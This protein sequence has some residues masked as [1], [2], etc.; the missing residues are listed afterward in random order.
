MESRRK[1]IWLLSL[2][3]FLSLAS[4]N[5]A[6]AGSSALTRFENGAFDI[7]MSMDYT[8]DATGKTNIE[9][10]LNITAKDIYRMTEGTHHIRRFYIYTPDRDTGATRQWDKA[11]IRF[12]STPN[13]VEGYAQLNG[14]LK[15]GKY[16]YIDEDLTPAWS[17][18]DTGNAIAH[19]MGHYIY[20]L[21]DEYKVNRGLANELIKGQ[22]HKNDTPKDTIMNHHNSFQRLSVSDDYPVGA[23]ETAQW[24]M[25]EESAW[26]VLTQPPSLDSVWSFFTSSYLGMET[27]RYHFTDLDNMIEPFSAAR[28]TQPTNNP[29]PEIIWMEG[30]EACIIID[31]SGSM[32]TD[33][34]IVQA[35]SGAKSY[36]DKLKVTGSN[37]D[38]AAVVSFSNSVSTVKPLTQ[39]TATIKNEF[40][41]A[42]DT[43]SAN[44]GTAIGSA[45]RSGLNILSASTR[46]GTFKYIILL[47]DGQNTSG[48]SPTGAILTDLKNA[49]IPVYCIGLGSG[50]D[51]STLNLIARA[52]NGKSY[53][54]SS[55]STLNSVYS[56][57]QSHVADDV[58]I[59]WE[60]ENLNLSRNTKLTT[61]RVD[62]SANSVVFS[63]AYPIDE[64]ATMN[65]TDPN[66]IIVMDGDPGVSCDTETGYI[67]CR[68]D[69]PV[70][71]DWQQQIEINS[72]DVGDEGEV[73]LEAKS[74]SEFRAQVEV[75]GGTYPEPIIIQASA[76]RDFP[77]TG[78]NATCKFT[79][80]D[81][82]SVKTTGSVDLFDDGAPPDREAD[83]GFYTGVLTDYQNGEYDFNVMFVNPDGNSASEVGTSFVA[84]FGDL[85]VPVP[86]AAAFSVGSNSSVT[87]SGVV[88]DDHTDLNSFPSEVIVDGN[89]VDGRIEIDNDID[90]FYFSAE[91]NKTY[92]I[93]TYGLYP[94]D[95]K[96]L[97]TVYASPDMTDVIASDSVGLNNESA[98]IV[99]ENTNLA[100]VY[101]T[102][103][104]S[105]PGTGN[106]KIAVRSSQAT[107]GAATVTTSG[108]PGGGGNTPA[109]SGG[110]GG[111]GG[112]GCF[113]GVINMLH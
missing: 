60:K 14:F 107:D 13:T 82:S 68:V 67:S 27:D 39:L 102:V 59:S 90:A 48:E 4:A 42:I 26:G 91:L 104:H 87:A 110:G 20:G 29:A 73:I 30:S 77:I 106:Y 28:L 43:L 100:T 84:A 70:A 9:T 71:G 11:D 54:A 31:R 24:R 92:T 18:G 74:N 51:M 40:K 1:V 94:N 86:V 37:R 93:Y 65:L 2:I 5:I 16:I 32:L 19:E 64:T 98:K 101:L 85:P 41:T 21:Y 50:A 53:F 89:P 76:S 95:M 52:T 63:S 49:N 79:H 66:G 112:G 36:L 15:A 46:K 57:I 8:P 45:L 22:P 23:R 38:Y 58:L 7:V 111:G 113:I 47:T 55:G 103:Q 35:K 75:K 17:I 96:T 78:L 97:L 109:P 72:F 33:G 105:S 61:V 25:Y 88:A 81:P 99:L 44:G 56:D 83:D 10:L 69:N 34:K 80:T 6:L 108:N 62:A 3:F 12:K